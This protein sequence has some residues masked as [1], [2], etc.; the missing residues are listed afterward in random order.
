MK[1]IQL[2]WSVMV[3]ATLGVACGDNELEQKGFSVP[4]T[5]GKI[6]TSPK[7]GIN[8]DSL[9][10]A[11]R[12]GNLLLTGFSEYRITPVYMVN[13]N[14]RTESYFIGSNNTHS[15]Y[16][17]W[18]EDNNWN[19]NFMPGFEAVYGYNMVGASLFYAPENR[20]IEFFKEPVLIKTLYFPTTSKDTLM[21]TPVLRDFYMI[22]VYN[23]DTNKDGFINLNDLRRLFWF[24]VSGEKQEALVPENY[25]V[26]KSEYDPYLD[27]MIITAQFDT[28]NNG[29]RDQ[30]EPE[31][32]FWVD[33]KNPHSTGVLY[34]PNS[35]IS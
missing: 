11:T 15:S 31:H 7:K 1:N 18:G 27:R 35:T 10:F 29:Q 4:S 21:G 26:L 6:A 14:P 24:N 22:S 33:L 34:Q 8:K 16:S 3:M 32:I 12:P 17:N 13:Y 30:S 28:N 25:S 19:Y 5:D 9:D 20:A 23:E 2:F